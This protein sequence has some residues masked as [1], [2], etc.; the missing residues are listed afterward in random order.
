MGLTVEQHHFFRHNGF[1][2][3]PERIPSQ[4]IA[5]LKNTILSHIEDRVEP[6]TVDQHN[7]PIRISRIWERGGIFQSVITHPCV[8]NPLETL[9]GPNIEYLLNRHNH[10]TLRLKDDH[11][12]AMSTGIHRDVDQW[13]RTIVTVLFYLED[14]NLDNGCTYVVPGT[15]LAQG[16]PYGSPTIDDDP[17]LRASGILDQRVPV[18]MPAG[19]LLAID[20]M[21]FHAAGQNKTDGSR[22][23]MTAGYHS[24]DDFAGVSDPKRVLVCGEKTYQGNDPQQKD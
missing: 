5:E 13:T 4:I 6:I 23:S 17:A 24:V 15:H 9:L 3:L 7:R 20:S 10:A 11:Y 8:L 2:K 19:G 21:L 14:T 16:R 1:I 22:I 12:S 18:P